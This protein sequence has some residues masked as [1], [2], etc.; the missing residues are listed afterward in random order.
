MEKIIQDN[1]LG[2]ILFRTSARAKHYSLKITKGKITA[3]MP[4]GGNTT[5]MWQF[6]QENKEKLRKA[7]MKHPARPLINEQTELQT[8]TFRTHIFLSD[9]SNFYMKLEKEI[10]H[11]A[12]P[13]ETDFTQEDVQTLLKGFIENAL[14]FEAKRILPSRLQILAQ[15][16]GFS[17]T[18][19]KIQNSKSRWGSCTSKRSINLSLSIM[20][21]PWHLIDYVLLHE[22]CHTIEM[23]HSERFWKIM[24]KVTE[25]K[26]LSL[27]K[28]LKNY[29]IL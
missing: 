16:H 13:K 1:E 7:L 25:N 4:I 9:R 26:A 29:H 27:N 12:C 2:E 3:T 19:V 18:N 20:L 6:I 24:D 17:Y 28:E 10:L 5:R 23:N 11:I 21:L 22:L 8:A 15:K 14:R